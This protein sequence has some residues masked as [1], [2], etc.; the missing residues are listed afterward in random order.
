[1]SFMFFSLFISAKAL[2]SEEMEKGDVLK[3][4]SIVFSISEAEELKK[5]I[6]ELEDKERRLGIYEDL[7]NLEKEKTSLCNDKI[8]IYFV[9]QKNYLEII[10]EYD[11]IITEKNKQIRIGKYENLGYFALGATFIVGSFYMTSSIINSQN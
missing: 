3:E 1:M 11:S 7:Y 5:R 6:L 10:S 8:D 2:A 4:D 9:K